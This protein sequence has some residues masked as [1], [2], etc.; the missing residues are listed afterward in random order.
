MCPWSCELRT[1]T[2]ALRE[3]D[4]VETEETQRAI[5][6]V[7]DMANKTKFERLKRL[8]VADLELQDTVQYGGCGVSAVLSTVP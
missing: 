5:A 2:A 8:M 6:Y 1:S 7:Q 3:R 4:R